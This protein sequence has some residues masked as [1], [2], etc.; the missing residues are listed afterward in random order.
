MWRELLGSRQHSGRILG[1]IHSAC[2][3][4]VRITVKEGDSE[5]RLEIRAVTN[6][7]QLLT[8]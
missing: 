7:G 1:S 3:F 8:R 2:G 6:E 4:L 5:V